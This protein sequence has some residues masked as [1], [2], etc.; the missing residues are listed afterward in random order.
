MDIALV[1]NRD[2]PQVIKI[3]EE[4]KYL[5]HK[6][7]LLHPHKI[8]IDIDNPALNYD[9]FAV[10]VSSYSSFHSIAIAE[11]S[12]IP[13]IN[14]LDAIK[15]THDKIITDIILRKNKIPRP[16]AY[17]A[18]SVETLLDL[19]YSFN[20]PMILKPYNGSKNEALFVN[21]IEAIRN[22]KNF[23]VL[24]LQEYIP[25]DGYDRKIY[26]VGDEVFGILRQSPLVKSYNSKEDEIRKTYKVPEEIKEMA[27]K[28]GEIFNLDI[29]GVDF[30]ENGNE[31]CKVV[32]INDF[33]GFRGIEK[34]GKT[35]AEYLVNYA[36]A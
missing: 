3:L 15:K 11:E 29:Y 7:H 18:E 25:N 6:P 8:A 12:G 17:F 26:V 33:P 21:D 24:Y 5:G 16:R 36:K 4:I 34:A 22:T 9:L 31:T 30:I 19:E 1:A 20:F 23:D 35:I 27:L 13:T 2:H 32:D 28:C 10:K 14:K